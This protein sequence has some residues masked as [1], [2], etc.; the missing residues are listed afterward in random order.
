MNFQN[1]SSRASLRYRLPIQDCRS[2]GFKCSWVVVNTLWVFFFIE[3]LFSI[4]YF[5]CWL[6]TDQEQLANWPSRSEQ[7]VWIIG[8]LVG[9]QPRRRLFLTDQRIARII[10]QNVGQTTIELR[11]GT[12][13]IFGWTLVL[14]PLDSQLDQCQWGGH[15]LSLLVGWTN[16]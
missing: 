15:Q 13:H 11:E 16:W 5:S 12:Y 4:D 1:V 10:I 8:W 7:L 14:C 3:I 9:D 6:I 2:F